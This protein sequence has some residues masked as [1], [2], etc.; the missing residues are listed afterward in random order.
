VVIEGSVEAGAEIV[1]GGSVTV[2][3]GIV[4]SETSVKAEATLAAKFVQDARLEAR[5]DVIVDSYLHG[6][7]VVSGGQVQ[8]EGSGGGIVGGETWGLKGIRALNIGA[9]ASSGTELFAGLEPSQL[10]HLQEI[11]TAIRTAED[12]LARLLATSGLQS[13]DQEEVDKV[14]GH[15]ESRQEAVQ[16][17]VD[18]AKQHNENREAK[19]CEEKEL[20]EHI[21]EVAKLATI[22]VPEHA[23]SRV[24]V[25]I[26]ANHRVVAQDETH[27]RFRVGADDDIVSSDLG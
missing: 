11:R 21:A 3:Q 4:G 2:G 26:G 17:A 10:P 22:E 15:S 1:A 20:T 14:A 24:R 19:M 12:M 9:E 16:Q 6:A 13:F 8:V 25:Q 7:F 5:G 27:V 23:H 18:E